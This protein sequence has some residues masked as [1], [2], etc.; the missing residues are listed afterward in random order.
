MP[1]T[2]AVMEKLHATRLFMQSCPAAK[3]SVCALGKKKEKHSVIN[4]ASLWVTGKLGIL[5]FMHF[6]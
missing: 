4:S 3:I 2:Q 5:F 1:I 6:C